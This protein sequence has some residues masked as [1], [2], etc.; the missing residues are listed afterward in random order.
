MTYQLYLGRD[1]EL[2]DA[3]NRIFNAWDWQWERPLTRTS[4]P[5]QPVDVTTALS[6]VLSGGSARRLPVGIIGP[7]E[8]TVDQEHIAEQ[9]G[10]RLAHLGLTIMC[11]GR[12]GVMAAAAK[13]ARG[14]GGLT[15]GILPGQDW[16]SA[17]SDILVPVATGL[18]EARNAI[19]ARASVAIVAV[20]SSHG[21]LTEIAFGLHFARP[22][23]GTAG[24]PDI[25]GIELVNT[26]EDVVDRIAYYLLVFNNNVT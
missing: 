25:A 10:R 2:C 12:G 9:I 13:G 18:G 4:E 6:A 15:I 20:G 19:I 3:E 5:V 16:R 11:G 21:T 1:G 24:A 17:N 23:I 8:A 7:R 14:A 26:V 22:V